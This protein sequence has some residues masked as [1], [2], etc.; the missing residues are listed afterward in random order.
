MEAA[1]TLDL[2]VDDEYAVGT[3]KSDDGVPMWPKNTE[4][5][6]TGVRYFTLEVDGEPVK[7]LPAE[8]D[9]KAKLSVT[10]KT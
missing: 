6:D 5:L 9:E 2:S 7:G 10:F 8:D 4:V 1:D 3:W